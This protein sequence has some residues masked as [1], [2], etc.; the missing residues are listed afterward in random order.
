LKAAELAKNY[1]I[2]EGKEFYNTKTSPNPTQGVFDFSE[3]IL[4]PKKE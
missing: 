1:N 4:R 3:S 2:T